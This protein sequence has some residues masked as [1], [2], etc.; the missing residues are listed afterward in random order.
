MAEVLGAH[1][2]TYMCI[3]AGG[4]QYGHTNIERN[5]NPTQRTGGV[6]YTQGKPGLLLQR[7]HG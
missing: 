5:L 7:L 1:D 2:G 3:S 6:A 4:R